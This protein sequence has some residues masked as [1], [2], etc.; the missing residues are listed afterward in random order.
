MTRKELNEIKKQFSNENCT[1]TR[2][3][4]CYVDGDKEIKAT[5][6]E[7]FLSMEEEER[8]KYYEIFKK[9]LSGTP[10]RNQLTLAFP[11]EQ[12]MQ[13]GTQEFL[14]RLLKSE[15]KEDDLLDTF[16][17]NIIESYQYTGNFLILL[18]RAA[19]D[20]PGKSKDNLEM[21][22]A[23]DEV[24]EHILCSICPVNLSKPGLSYD[25]EGNIFRN[26]IQDWIVEQ[27]QT[28]FLFPAFNDRETDVH[29]IQYYTKNT[30]NPNESFVSFFI[31][32]ELPLSA[33]TQKETFQALV[34]DTLGND[35]EY[36]VVQN[37]HERLTEMIEEHKDEPE[38]LTL[39][40][41]GVK[42]L[43]AE[44]GV[45]NEKLEAFDRTFEATIEDEKTE[46]LAINI[47]NTRS[48]EVKTPDV[49]I[50]VNP[51]HAHLVETM[52]IDGRRCLV[53]EMGENVEVNGI[54]VS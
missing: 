52:M 25:A 49:L 26:R 19:Y 44:S 17:A 34:A 51:E 32:C 38:P 16:Y 20:V 1:I 47:A 42:K 41:E 13:G 22:D 29:S 5:F 54:T 3:C 21:D 8:F 2:I 23:S 14:Y 50:K 9:T 27:P 31:G 18:I 12:E 48:F 43:F 40:K 11:M 7:A 33:E 28:G 30:E 46:L 53:I 10:G 36:T 15:L 4:G 37:I 45:D 6:K 39:D 24:F 35:C